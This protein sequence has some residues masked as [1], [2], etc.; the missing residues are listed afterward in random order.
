M[1]SYEYPHPALTIDCVVFGFDG[2]G[3]NLLLVERGLKPYKGKWA[4]PGGFVRIDETLEEG[5][6][7]ELREET[8]VMDIYIE[9]LQAFSRV[10]R[11]PRERV[12]T[13]AF[14]AFVRQ[15]DYEVIAGDDAAKAQWFPVDMLPDLAFDHS[16][17]PF[18]QQRVYDDTGADHLR[19]GAREEV[20]PSKLPQKDDR[21]GL[22]C[23]YRWCGAAKLRS[24]RYS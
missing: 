14:L 13:V 5:A 3:L 19:G 17:I 12:V 24:V 10:D 18:A 22:H 11:D 2:S 4:L 6:L 1:Y 23:G 7:R 9:Q 8:G 16:G 20:R 15:E 21:H